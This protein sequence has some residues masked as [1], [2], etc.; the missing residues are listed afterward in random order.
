MVGQSPPLVHLLESGCT[1]S[2]LIM[3]QAGNKE[4]VITEV[5]PVLPLPVS[6]TASSH[7]YQLP[8]CF[9]SGPSVTNIR[10]SQSCSQWKFSLGFS[11]LR[12]QLASM[13]T[14]VQSLASFSRLRIWHFESCGAGHRYGS[15]MVLLWL[16][17][18]PAATA[19]IQPLA[20]E[21]SYAVGVTLKSKAKQ[22]NKNRVQ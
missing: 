2:H 17:H 14:Q 7:L 16:W 13:R 22:T 19:P 12:T 21:F 1:L 4:G 9:P 3:V 11:R 8:R 10:S 20:W 18:R 5:L 6:S 15:D